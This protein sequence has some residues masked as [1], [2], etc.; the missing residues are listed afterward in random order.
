MR[1]RRW[2]IFVAVIVFALAQFTEPGWTQGESSPAA[3]VA[4]P[5]LEHVDSQQCKLCHNK[6]HEGAQFSVWQSMGHANA[7]ETLF[8]KRA[9]KF[10][11]ERGLAVPPSEAA[12]CLKCHVTGYDEATAS[13]PSQLKIDSGVQ[14]GSCHGPASAHLADGKTLRMDKDAVIDLKANLFQPNTALCVTCHNPESPPWNPEKY[15]L[16]S[17]ETV[18]FDFAQAWDIIAHHNPSKVSGE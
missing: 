17:G 14:C 11:E 7:Y 10:A 9:L 4:R 18:G 16:E 1:I 8:E 6:P 3:A 13:Y 12:E 2:G 15:T 5:G